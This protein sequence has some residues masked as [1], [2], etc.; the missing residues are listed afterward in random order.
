MCTRI[1][2]RSPP[3]PPPPDPPPLTPPLPPSPPV[4]H[5]L[6]PPP[7]PPPPL[8]PRI[9]SNSRSPLACSTCARARTTFRTRVS[10]SLGLSRSS[11]T[12]RRCASRLSMGGR[13]TREYRERSP[14]TPYPYAYVCSRHTK[15]RSSLSAPPRGEKATAGGHRER[16]ARAGSVRRP[17]SLRPQTA[18]KGSAVRARA[19]WR[20]LPRL[21][22]GGEEEE[23]RGLMDG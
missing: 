14:Q 17:R 2:S 20:R 6:T 19:R 18:G 12:S 15:A 22:R 16:A 21:R 23:E 8:P 3:Y 13:S 5:P 11:A 7:Y 4:P 9:H 1:S 10:S